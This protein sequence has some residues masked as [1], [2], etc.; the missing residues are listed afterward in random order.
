MRRKRR[1]TGLVTLNVL[2]KKQ[3]LQKNL[4][5]RPGFLKP[6]MKQA[7]FLLLSVVVLSFKI[8]TQEMEVEIRMG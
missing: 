1:R 7:G 3:N 4:L 8:E 5:K 2:R 6:P